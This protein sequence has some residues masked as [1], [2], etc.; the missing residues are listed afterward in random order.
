MAPDIE[1]T[2][3]PHAGAVRCHAVELGA[4]SAVGS[5]DELAARLEG[6][7]PSRYLAKARRAHHEEDRLA[8]LAVGALLATR[9]GIARDEQLSLGEWGKPEPADA[10]F[11]LGI[12]H[13]RRLVAVCLS[14]VV[15]GLDAA[16][17]PPRPR[18]VDLLALARV[19]QALPTGGPDAPRAL[20]GSDFARLWTQAEAVLKAEGTGLGA[21]LR[22]HPDWF[23]R[24]PCTWAQ[25]C[26][27]VLCTATRARLP[28]RVFVEAPRTL[29][30]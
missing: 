25:A 24:W 20:S 17:V 26:G 27:H 11:H 21:D 1:A 18:R 19:G 8:E 3:G 16:E 6:R 4:L 10:S 28:L 22:A 2:P 15:V 30:G 23:D 5:A 14:P 29:L 12:T 7:I 9:C 13:T